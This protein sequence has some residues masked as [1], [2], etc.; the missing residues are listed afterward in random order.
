M[1]ADDSNIFYVD[2]PLI[3]NRFDK[4]LT[5]ESDQTCL[6]ILFSLFRSTADTKLFLKRMQSYFLKIVG[7]SLSI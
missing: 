2:R 7:T 6:R 1:F 4:Y 5:V 3:S